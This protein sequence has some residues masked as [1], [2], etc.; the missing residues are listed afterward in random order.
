MKV[1]IYEGEEEKIVEVIP[2]NVGDTVYTTTFSKDS[3]NYRTFYSI[4][5]TIDTVVPQKY[6]NFKHNR[7]QNPKDIYKYRV[8]YNGSNKCKYGSEL[9]ATKK[10]ASYEAKRKQK[11]FDEKYGNKL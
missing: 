6:S 4:E 10:A 7:R 2:F 8:H 9:F 1:K 5:G 3:R 11:E